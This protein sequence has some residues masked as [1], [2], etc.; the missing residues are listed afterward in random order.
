MAVTH[1]PVTPI[2]QLYILPQG[3]EAMGFG[4]HSMGAFA[5][6]LGQGIINRVGLTQADDSGISR[7]GVSLLPGGSGR[8]SPASIHRLS[9]TVVTQ[10]RP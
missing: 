2:R 9:Q 3:D 7:H 1:Y 6:K 4:E 10:I 5:G 8:L